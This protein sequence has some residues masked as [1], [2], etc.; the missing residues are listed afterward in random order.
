MLRAGGTRSI[1][2]GVAGVV[3]VVAL[4]AGSAAGAVTRAAAP[5]V[6]PCT[7]LT[8]DELGVALDSVFQP[9]SP[10]QAGTGTSCGFDGTGPV[11]GATVRVASGK[12]AKVA[13]ARTLKAL[14]Q[15]LRDID[16][17]PPTKVA[18]LGDKAWYSL[19]E[20]L[21]E[22]SIEV[23]NGRTFVQVT[24]IVAPSGDTAAVSETVLRGLAEQALARASA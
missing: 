21:G 1:V 11:R 7:L 4:T 12:Q 18:G 23:L 9:G 2:A 22:G 15:T 3:A 6:D 16:S 10:Y 20:F 13:M 5:K 19:D 24:A 17:G 8:T 14:R